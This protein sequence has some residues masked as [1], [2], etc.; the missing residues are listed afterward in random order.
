M[1]FNSILFKN[2]PEE[3][4][5][6]KS[7]PSFF[8]DLNLDQVVEAA[9]K[10]KQDYNLQPYFYSPLHD[11]DSIAY[12]QAV[13]QDLENDFLYETISEFAGKMVLVRR[14]LGVVEKSH[15]KFHQMGWQ[16][17]AALTYCDAILNL[18]ER[19]QRT[20][21]KSQG[22]T[23]FSRILLQYHQ[24]ETFRQ[25]NDE[26][27]NIKAKLSSIQYNLVIKGLTVRVRKNESEIDYSQE[28]EGFFSKFKQSEVKDFRIDLTVASGMNH[29]EE[30]I[31]DIVAKLYPDIFDE[32]TQFSLHHQEFIDETINVFDREIQFYLAYL[33]FYHRIR[34]PKLQFCY[35]KMDGGS[36]EIFVNDTYDVALAE[37]YR[38]TNQALIC[39][40]F[41]LEGEERIFIVSGA[42][43]GGK[44]TFARMFGQLHFLA[45]LGCPIPGREAKLFIFDQIF[46][47]FEQEEDIQNLR[48][49]LK[50]DLVRINQILDQATGKSIIIMNEIFTSTSLQ[51]AIF[52]SKKILEKIIQL[53]ALSV[54][55]TF[56][57]ELSRLSKQTVS[58][59]STVDP[60]NTSVRTF[61]LIRKPADGRAYAI[62]IARQYSLTHDSIV[63]RIV[64]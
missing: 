20:K 43:Q 24:S 50:D 48:G 53:D 26:A 18:S 32:L 23:G 40:D 45:S 28:V 15:F 35:P 54:C 62:D 49:K 42:N 36:K 7:E 63:E 55:V 39:N 12:R 16:L 8:T 52:L 38:I 34:Q 2:K 27:L 13:F 4:P 44:T 17:E 25:L 60:N 64:K 47:H 14:Y 6:I 9:T 30:K 5:I 1:T 3:Y 33:D 41:Y 22:F 51:D 19:L 21:I 59:V 61:K 37:K 11:E 29:V 57:E 46:T 31:L 58:K 56:I 10:G